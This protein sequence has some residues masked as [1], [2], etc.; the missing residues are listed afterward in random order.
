MRSSLAACVVCLLFAACSSEGPAGGASAASSPALAA[1]SQSTELVMSATPPPSSSTQASSTP[2]AAEPPVAARGRALTTLLSEGKFP[3]VAKEFDAAMSAALPEAKLAEMWGGLVKQAGPFGGIAGVQVVAAGAYQTAVVTTRF[4]QSSLDL[5]LAFDASGKVSGLFVSATPAPWSL[6]SYADASRFE[7]REVVVG[8]DPWQL[9]GTLTLPKGATKVPVVILVH[10]SGPGDRDESIGPNRPFKDLAAGL[11]S[12]GVAV[13]RYEKRTRQHGPK[14]DLASFGLDDESVDDALAAVELLSKEAA[15]DPA[16]IYVAGHSLGGT[17]A[18]RIAQKA[19]GVAGVALLAG[20]T[21]RVP[22]MMIE[23]LE[24]IASLDGA[25]SAE[26]AAQIEGVKKAKKR[27]DEIVGGAAAKPGEVIL[28]AGP[29]YWLELGKYDPVATA[30]GVDTR[31]FV[32]QGGRDYQVTEVD[33]K[34]WQAAL[35]GKK[36]SV[37]KL[38]PSLNHI[39]VTGN[40]KSVPDEYQQAGHVDEALV[41]D[42]AAW[43]VG[44]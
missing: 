20:A 24:Y 32:A 11:A 41:N 14:I 38:Y 9:P 17:F 23:Q 25:R 26:E 28:G 44:S 37:F 39:F 31:F 42:L 18:P 1:P 29:K 19:K 5:K 10:G 43:I 3:E 7:E 12:R 34:A 27:V 33:F 2:P 35:S 36:G 40:G 8:A 15:V 13:L 22:E 4:G 16:R 21:R 6:P 30:K